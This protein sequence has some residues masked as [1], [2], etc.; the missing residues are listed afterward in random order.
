VNQVEVQTNNLAKLQT[1][2]TAKEEQI[3]KRESAILM[4]LE[5]LTVLQVQKEKEL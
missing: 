4:K 3:L 2:V 5:D 1:E